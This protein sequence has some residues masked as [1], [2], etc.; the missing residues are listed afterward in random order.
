MAEG[1]KEPV[2]IDLNLSTSHDKNKQPQKLSRLPSDSS[3]PH[4]KL[5]EAKFHQQKD[6][7]ESYSKK[8][9]MAALDSVV[10]LY[11]ELK[12]EWSKATPNLKK[13]G[14]YLEQLKVMHNL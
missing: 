8:L 12:T 7:Q 5:F 3:N 11:K 10:S 14:N 6:L 1:G 4:Q 2:Q 13:C 9:K